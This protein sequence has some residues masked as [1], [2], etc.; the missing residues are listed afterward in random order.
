M[1]V[2]PMEI[3]RVKNELYCQHISVLEESTGAGESIDYQFM[4][5][6]TTAGTQVRLLAHD[7]EGKL[8]VNVTRSIEMLNG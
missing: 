1:K 2:G 7:K 5:E 6:D 4:T 3:N 8:I